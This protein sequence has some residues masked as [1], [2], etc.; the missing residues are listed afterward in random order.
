MHELAFGTVISVAG[1]A[2]TAAAGQAIRLRLRLAA[3]DAEMESMLFLSKTR[4][5]ICLSCFLLSVEMPTGSP[6]P[7]VTSRVTQAE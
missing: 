7:E 1:E 4:N 5:S 2:A 6:K 3:V